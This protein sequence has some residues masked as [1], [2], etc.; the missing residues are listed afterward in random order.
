MPA[1]PAPAP[2]AH[3]PA[4]ESHKYSPIKTRTVPLNSTSGAD[5]S[6]DAGT[7]SNMY[8]FAHFAS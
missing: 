5:D 6:L 4:H 8:H 1:Q 3:I 7:F 2:W